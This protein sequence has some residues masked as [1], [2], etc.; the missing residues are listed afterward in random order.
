MESIGILI[1]IVGFAL[2]W[3]TIVVVVLAG[4]STGLRIY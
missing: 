3:D 4:I 2:K 1:I